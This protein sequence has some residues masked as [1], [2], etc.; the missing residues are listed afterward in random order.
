MHA[1]TD[2]REIVRAPLRLENKAQRSARGSTKAE[3]SGRKSTLVPQLKCLLHLLTIIFHYTS[4]HAVTVALE[5]SVK[6]SVSLTCLKRKPT[7]TTPQVQETQD[8]FTYT[9]LPTL[10]SIRLLKF[11]DDKPF[12]TIRFSLV[13]VELAEAPDFEALSYT[14]Q[15]PIPDE[16]LTA[17]FG[18]KLPLQ[19]NG[20]VLMITRNLHDALHQMHQPYDLDIAS[21]ELCKTYLIAATEAGFTDTVTYLLA[22]HVN[23]EAQDWHGNTA[24]HYAAEKGYLNIVKALLVAGARTDLR[25]HWGRTALDCA[26]ET[27]VRTLI[28]AHSGHDKPKELTDTC[29]IKQ[30]VEFVLEAARNGG[31]ERLR[32]LIS[33]G[34][35]LE[36]RDAHR[37]TALHHA[38]GDGDIE[39]VT[40]LVEAGADKR[41]LDASAKM[42]FAAAQSHGHSEVAAILRSPWCQPKRLLTSR[43]Q[44]IW[45]DAVCIN[46]FNDL[47][48]G[49]QVAM[50]SGIYR[51]AQAVR[52]WLGRTDCDANLSIQCLH[53]LS[54]ANS[55]QNSL[56]GRKWREMPVHPVTKLSS[57]EERAFLH[58]LCRRWFRRRWIIQELLS[59]R[60]I[61]MNCGEHQISWQDI[62]AAVYS[63][64]D[65]TYGGNFE[66]QMG[67]REILLPIN[68]RCILRLS[69]LRVH[70]HPEVDRSTLYDL[71][72]LLL[73]T[74]D[75]QCSNSFDQIYSL[76]GIANI[77]KS[78]SRLLPLTDYTEQPRK[79]FAETAL[80]IIYETGN[81]SIL[82]YAQGQVMK[83]TAVPSWVPFGIEAP[84]PTFLDRQFICWPNKRH[85]KIVGNYRAA[86]ELQMQIKPRS[87]PTLLCL[88]AFLFGMIDEVE[89]NTSSRRAICGPEWLRLTLLLKKT[90][91]T[92]AGNQADVL[93][94]TVLAGS[95]ERQRTYNILQTWRDDKFNLCRDWISH[96][97]W[98]MSRT[99][100]SKEGTL[101]A[102]LTLEYINLLTEKG[103]TTGKIPSRDEVRTY[104]GDWMTTRLK[105][106]QEMEDRAEEFEAGES[107][108]APALTMEGR[109][110]F[111]TSNGCMGKGPMSA[112]AGHS[113]WIVPGVNVPLILE[114]VR[115][116]RYRLVGEAFVHGIMYGE[117]LKSGKVDFQ[118]IEIE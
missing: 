43:P 16:A 82:T 46:Q 14:W 111:L 39:T 52:V 78:S 115:P 37:R 7:M 80:H 81:L 76:L 95:N 22:K 77:A 1:I 101:N 15:N 20:S 21:G 25:D 93:W 84:L 64:V 96:S 87:D 114:N 33:T 94:E 69:R 72:Q 23:T 99:K 59:A 29:Q 89:A 27:T 50:M 100:A 55:Q 67:E 6:D 70:Y 56:G 17:E 91:A 18:E 74:S 32:D 83:A 42:P 26:S 24:L 11:L 62:S 104:T 31:C 108:L 90:S 47:E 53:R 28:I 5:Y 51:S 68:L 45:V 63:F 118:E 60:Y 98:T 54:D 65:W 112:K 2:Y 49:S 8:I 44:Y 79:T 58:F 97:V 107:Y 88:K 102:D 48:R 12:D 38:A 92:S 75:F 117:A 35:N 36:V 57:E 9:N 34:C 30:T 73:A 113:I 10:T 40:S 3:N 85:P 19:C 71:D 13:T 105:R 109:N 4:C 66:R 106:G 110:I 86:D 61:V 103:N 41:A 116:G